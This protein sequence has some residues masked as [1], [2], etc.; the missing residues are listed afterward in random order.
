MRGL[1]PQPREGRPQGWAGGTSTLPWC[2]KVPVSE[3]R[4]SRPFL[5]GE[6]HT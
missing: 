3:Q 1:G 4:C 6:T 5:G 2:L